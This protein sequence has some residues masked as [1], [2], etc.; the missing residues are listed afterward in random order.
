M[1]EGRFDDSE[2]MLRQAFALDRA[3]GDRL[4]TA[5]SLAQLG[6]A[7]LRQKRLC[8]SLA[9]DRGGDGIDQSRLGAT[10]R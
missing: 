10:I 6:K 4:A 7:Y 8:P 1:S 5:R 2:R 3:R 9:A